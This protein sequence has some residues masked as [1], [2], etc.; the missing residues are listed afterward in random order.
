[1]FS[2]LVVFVLGNTKVY[3]GISNC[4]NVLTN[5]KAPVD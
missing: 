2:F 4:G 5:V 3:I 1:M